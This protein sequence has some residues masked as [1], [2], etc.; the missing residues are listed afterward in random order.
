MCFKIVEIEADSAYSYL[1]IQNN[2][3]ICQIDGEPIRSL[4]TVMKMFGNVANMSNLNLGI[5]RDGETT[6]QTYNIE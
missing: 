2:D 5:R 3:T 1:G 4:N 6:T